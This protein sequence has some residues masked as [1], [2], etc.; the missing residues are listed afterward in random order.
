LYLVL[1]N[2]FI[3]IKLLLIK[4]VHICY[5]IHGDKIKVGPE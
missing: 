5:I 2:L 4:F 1:S 3:D